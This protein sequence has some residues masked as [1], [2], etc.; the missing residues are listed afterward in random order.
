M[1]EGFLEAGVR[2]AVT[3]EIPRSEIRMNR[4]SQAIDETRPVPRVAS[5]WVAVLAVLALFMGAA[6]ADAQ[7]FSI[8]KPK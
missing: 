8:I 4:K 2:D 7:G 1:E 6:P 3:S 5:G